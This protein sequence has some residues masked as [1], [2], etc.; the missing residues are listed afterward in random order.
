MLVAVTEED[1]TQEM[2]VFTTTTTTTTAQQ[3]LV[4]LLT[5]HCNA[6]NR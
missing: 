6:Y 1:A 3:V 5:A 4:D 2:T